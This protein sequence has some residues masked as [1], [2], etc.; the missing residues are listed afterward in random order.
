MFAGNDLD[1]ARSSGDGGGRSLFPGITGLE[2]NKA[3]PGI[4]TEEVFFCGVAGVDRVALLEDVEDK[5]VPSDM[6][7]GVWVCWGVLDTEDSSEV[8][9]S[10]SW[11]T[12]GFGRDRA[13]LKNFLMRAPIEVLLCW[14]ATSL[15][16]ERLLRGK[17]Q[18]LLAAR[19][20]ALSTTSMLC[21]P[22][23]LR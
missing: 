13:F 4:D 14:G 15:V 23:L 17:L 16:L 8:T 20:G 18:L 12:R 22:L 5:G 11:V 19:A 6:D 3:M 10:T 7:M 1:L 2:G 9:T 21:R